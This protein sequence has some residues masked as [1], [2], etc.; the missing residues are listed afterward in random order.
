MN[1][2]IGTGFLTF[3]TEGNKDDAILGKG[4]GFT[5]TATDGVPLG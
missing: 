4:M 1:D 3:T 5:L 2:M